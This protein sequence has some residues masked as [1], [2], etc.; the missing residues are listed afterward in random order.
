MKSIMTRVPSGDDCI[1]RKG[2]S[3]DDPCQNSKCHWHRYGYAYALH[4]VFGVTCLLGKI[5]GA[6]D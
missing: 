2:A 3:G 1:E 5:R 6:S 4:C